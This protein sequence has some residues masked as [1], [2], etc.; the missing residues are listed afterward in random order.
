M[1][2]GRKKCWFKGVGRTRKARGLD[3]ISLG[4]CLPS[5]GE[6]NVIRRP[7]GVHYIDS[8]QKL[9]RRLSILFP[10]RLDSIEGGRYL[11]L[12]VETPALFRYSLRGQDPSFSFPE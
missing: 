1:I 12:K 8:D 7:I 11:P 3:P 10:E 6:Y 4:F 9:F 2:G 5:R